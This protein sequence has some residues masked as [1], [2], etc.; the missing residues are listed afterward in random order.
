MTKNNAFLAS[1]LLIW[2]M[3]GGGIYTLS[4]AYLQTHSAH[5]ISDVTGSRRAGC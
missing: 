5:D 2:C 3:G 1:A 4:G